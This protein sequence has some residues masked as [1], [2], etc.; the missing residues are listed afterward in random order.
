MDQIGVVI[1]ASDWTDCPCTQARIVSEQLDSTDQLAV[2]LGPHVEDEDRC[3][4][5]LEELGADVV[6]RESTKNAAC[7]RNTGVAALDDGI[8]VFIFCDADDEITD[9]WIDTISGPLLDGTADLVGGI[10][11][12]RNHPESGVTY[13]PR[14]DYWHRQSVMGGNMGLTREAWE[15]MGGFDESLHYV[16]DMD[17]AWRA[18]EMGLT[19]EV[20]SDAVVDY[21]LRSPIT[22]MRQRFRWG[23]WAVK[24]LRKHD[25]SSENLPTLK[26]LYVDKRDTKFASSPATAAASQWIG[27]NYE[28]FTGGTR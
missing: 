1:P 23:K 12:L 3:R 15:A 28:R 26:Q 27:Q 11:H 13:A 8:N 9:G 14:V 16:E 10:L 24:L 20:V 25:L 4:S 21:T 19:V 7:A 22:E 2:V 5:R 18:G 17:I 6:F